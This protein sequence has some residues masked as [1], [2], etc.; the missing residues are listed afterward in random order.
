MEFALAKF[1]AFL[2][3]SSS[4]YNSNVLWNWCKPNQVLP[5][6]ALGSLFKA[7]RDSQLV[8]VSFRLGFILHGPCFSVSLAFYQH[9][10]WG[11]VNYQPKAP[12]ELPPPASAY[13]PAVSLSLAI[14]PSVS[15]KSSGGIGKI[16]PQDLLCEVA[17][18]LQR[19]WWLCSPLLIP[20][21]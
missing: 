6:L 19:R 1:S 10:G 12:L 7:T 2:L 11:W 18:R 5:S 16:G 20:H 8:A 21:I 3:A 15:E 4:G 9:R 17:V 14:D 13:S